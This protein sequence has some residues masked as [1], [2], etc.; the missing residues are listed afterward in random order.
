[1]RA[2]NAELAAAG[3]TLSDVEICP[4]RP[5]GWPPQEPSARQSWLGGLGVSG[6][7]GGRLP[8][9]EEEIEAE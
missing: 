7:P 2:S 9:T 1:M 8:P 3:W 5:V 6:Y 4:W